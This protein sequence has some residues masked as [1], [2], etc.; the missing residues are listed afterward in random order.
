MK[1]AM[2]SLLFCNKKHLLFIFPEHIMC[3]TRLKDKR[4][5]GNNLKRGGIMHQVDLNSDLG[6]GFGL[7][8]IGMD[9]QIIRHVSS[10]NIGCGFHGGDPVVM[11][12]TVAACKAG[13]VT[14][15]AH[16][17]FPDL[18]G[19]GRR[20]MAVSP[21]EAKAYVTYQLGAL[22]AFATAHGI[23]V[24][25]V[26]PHGALYNMAAVDL[27]LATAIAEAVYEVDPTL[28]F[29]GLANS[30][31]ITAAKDVGLEAASEVFADRA[32]NADGTLVSRT[33]PGSM[34]HDTAICIERVLR[35]VKENKLTAITGEEISLV[36]HSICV[37]GDTPEAVDFVIA[38]RQAL[39][40]EGVELCNL[41]S[42]LNA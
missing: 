23:R 29:L 42:V 26:K 6:E 1:T 15:G 13:N 40:A 39:E 32:Y 7:Y 28:I 4:A 38:I 11:E 36:P 5:K 10:A 27:T 14:I 21:K 33:T 41:R 16:P 8:R 12:D 19:F 35:M 22:M 9:D 24:E 2:N 30:C 31:M 18:M 34:I 37:H 3:F 20:N 17:G 25:H